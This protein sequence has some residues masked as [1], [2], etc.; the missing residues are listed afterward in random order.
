VHVESSVR[1]YITRIVRATREEPAFAIG[2]SPRAG[3]ALFLAARAAAFL[4]GRD[5]TTPDDVKSLTR[6]ALRHRV[7]LTPEAEVEGGGAAMAIARL[8]DR[9]RAPGD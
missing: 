6:A 1:D 3:V 7:I 2:A 4:E 8:L 5:F 9:V